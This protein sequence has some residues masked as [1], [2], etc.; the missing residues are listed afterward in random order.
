MVSAASTWVGSIS[1]DATVN[2][3][4]DRDIRRARDGARHIAP[5]PLLHAISI[6]RITGAPA[7]RVT[8]EANRLRRFATHGCHESALRPFSCS[9]SS[10]PALRKARTAVRAE[11]RRQKLS[12]VVRIV[13]AGTLTRL[14]T[15]VTGA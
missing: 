14:F 3:A 2:D 10:G 7:R 9:L 4:T 15:R 11:S 6:L 13:P 12:A 1:A 5:S 8:I